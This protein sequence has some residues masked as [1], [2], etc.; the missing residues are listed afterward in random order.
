MTPKGYEK[1]LVVV[2]DREH[3][4]DFPALDEEPEESL[5][6]RAGHHPE[7]GAGTH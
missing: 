1:P 3:R 5:Y 4:V 6:E 7:Y 2:Q